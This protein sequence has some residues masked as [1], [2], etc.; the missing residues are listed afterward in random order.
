MERRWGSCTIGT[1]R[2]RIADTLGTAP[3]H[4]IEAVVFHELV[5]LLES[6]HS[7]RFRSL[8]R[9]YPHHDLARNWLRGW[10]AG[11]AAADREAGR[12]FVEPDLDDEWDDAAFD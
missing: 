2:I 10:S 5:H 1:G 3:Q 6:R 7:A 11:H 8:E 4:V 12:P 9:L